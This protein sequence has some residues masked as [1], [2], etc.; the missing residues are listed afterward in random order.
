MFNVTAHAT[1]AQL[2]AQA[3]TDF[4][5]LSWAETQWANWYLWIGNPV[6]ATGI[7]SFVMHELVYFGRSLMWIIVDQI[8]YFKKFKIQEVSSRRI[9]F[10]LS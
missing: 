8:P 9:P 6:L 5:A 1:A 7:M 3:G 4:S 10:C 2:Y